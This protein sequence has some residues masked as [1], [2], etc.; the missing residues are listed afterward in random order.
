MTAPVNES[1]GLVGLRNT[2]TKNKLTDTIIPLWEL[3]STADTIP[4]AESFKFV[5]PGAESVIGDDDR[6]KVS[7]EHFAPGGK[8]RCESLHSILQRGKDENE[9]RLNI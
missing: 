6:V 9:P 1:I 5:N 2:A 3:Q 7:P 4:T 8:Y